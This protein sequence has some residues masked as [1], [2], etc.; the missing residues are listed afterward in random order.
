MYE[1]EAALIGAGAALLAPGVPYALK[2]LGEIRPNPT[3]ARALLGRWKGTGADNYVENEGKGKLEFE[4]VVRFTKVGRRIVA[5]AIL[6]PANDS[7]RGS[8]HL[9]FLGTFFE[10]EA[11][12]L[13]LS[14]AHAGAARKQMGVVMLRLSADGTKLTGNYAGFSPSR[15]TIVAGRLTLHKEP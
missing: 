1:I 9:N 14:Y 11:D 8:Q 10:F 12:Y 7:V 4:M 6:E 2:R 5:T 13:Q 15:E 3:R